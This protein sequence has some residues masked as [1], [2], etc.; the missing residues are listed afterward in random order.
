[1]QNN[2]RIP[3]AMQKKQQIVSIRFPIE[4]SL[5]PGHLFGPVL[6]GVSRGVPRPARRGKSFERISRPPLGET[7]PTTL[8]IEPKSKS[9]ARFS[10]CGGHRRGKWKCALSQRVWTVCMCLVA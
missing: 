10:G 1:M 9:H 7:W 6:A 2:I 3:R 5:P 4:S 8:D